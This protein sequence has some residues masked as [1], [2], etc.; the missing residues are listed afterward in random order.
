M[1]KIAHKNANFCTQ[2]RR[3]N[4]HL[5][6][7]NYQYLWRAE[8]CLMPALVNSFAKLHDDRH[9]IQWVLICMKG[10][11]FVQCFL[12]QSTNFIQLSCKGP[13]LYVL[14]F[15]KESVTISKTLQYGEEKKYQESET[16]EYVAKKRIKKT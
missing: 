14:L 12:I 5:K 16:S 13:I 4:F 15:A 8:I 1:D 10:L 2:C 9:T 11:S 7:N 6:K 3:G